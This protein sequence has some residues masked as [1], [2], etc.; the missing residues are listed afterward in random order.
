MA[1]FINVYIGSIITGYT[2]LNCLQTCYWCNWID[3]YTPCTMIWYSDVC[4]KLYIKKWGLSILRPWFLVGVRIFDSF[5]FIYFKI[6]F[7]RFW[8]VYSGFDFDRFLLKWT[9]LPREG[10][11]A[12]IDSS[13]N[14]SVIFQIT[15]FYLFKLSN[16]KF[17]FQR[18][19]LNG[20]SKINTENCFVR[21]MSFLQN[22]VSK[23]P[24]VH[25][26]G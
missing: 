22:V 6:I 21:Y 3:H 11:N 26:H 17:I 7:L 13:V 14:N 16:Q 4:D 20:R 12:D 8:F 25:T 19:K 23:Q 2:C 9:W 15:Q 10:K 18:V 1:D 24:V 5:L